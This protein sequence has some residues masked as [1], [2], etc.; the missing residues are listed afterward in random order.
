MEIIDIRNYT[1][2]ENDCFLFDTN[3][4]V[5]LGEL[6]PDQN[7]P[8]EYSDFYEQILE[9]DI[10]PKIIL[11]NLG[12]VHNLYMNSKY[13]DLTREEKR[14]IT[15]KNFRKSDDGKLHIAHIN[16]HIKS[17]LELSSKLSD[18]FE[19][20]DLSKLLDTTETFDFNDN[21]ILGV[22]EKH[23]LIIVTHDSDF[24]EYKDSDVTI[25]TAN[26]NIS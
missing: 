22:A 16:R 21:Y 8:S 17:I 10:L 1:I 13:N 24:V 23:N 11:L 12:E 20:T 4:W 6:F 2:K 15:R 25:L 26:N 19:N 3:I 7:N 14:N 5:Y 9:K 18:D